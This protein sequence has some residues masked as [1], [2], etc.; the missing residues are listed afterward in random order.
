MVVVVNKLIRN[1]LYFGT[2]NLEENQI[3]STKEDKEVE[4]TKIPREVGD[5]VLLLH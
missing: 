5:I 1:L 3:E 4:K 2:I